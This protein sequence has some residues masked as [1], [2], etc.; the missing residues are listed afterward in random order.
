MKKLRT[1]A[2]QVV[3]LVFLAA[4]TFVV[5]VSDKYVV[6]IIMY[7]SVNDKA[8]EHLQNASTVNIDRFRYHMEFLRKN[9]FRVISFDELVQGIKSARP[10]PRKTVVLTFDDGYDDVYT[11]AFRILREYG[12][13]ATVFVLTDLIGREG[14]MTWDQLKEMRSS[15]LITVGSHTQTHAYL[16]EVPE[17]VQRKEIAQSKKILENVF[18]E[19]VKYFAYP[20]GGFTDAIKD[21]VR[22]AGY[23]AAC[24]TNRG[25]NR[26]NTDV[27]ALKRIRFSSKD[28]TYRILTVKLSGFYNLFR[29]EK[30]GY[31][32]K[33][34]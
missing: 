11:N 18:G 24:T 4:A 6:P 13:P 28:N 7:H 9:H 21:M 17:D 1:T 23:E 5:A 10:F 34:K 19:P 20:V 27:Y 22:A 3:F 33:G 8:L 12:Y 32:P 15:G 29:S 14:Y 25:F 30:P 2:T 16:P 26:F 31:G